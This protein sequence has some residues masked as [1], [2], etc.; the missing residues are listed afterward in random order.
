MAKFHRIC[1]HC[2]MPKSVF[3]TRSLA[4]VSTPSWYSSNPIGMQRRLYF[5]GHHGLLLWCITELLHAAFYIFVTSGF[6]QQD[7]YFP[8]NAKR[9][10]QTKLDR[11][12]CVSTNERTNE[13]TSALWPASVVNYCI[14]TKLLTDQSEGSKIMART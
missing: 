2:T 11:F 5:E 7:W 12:Y 6:Q 14:D 4:L 10:V 3:L 8:S 13:M 9:V 1:S